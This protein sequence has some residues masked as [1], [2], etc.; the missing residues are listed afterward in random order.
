ML[1]CMEI[2]NRLEVAALWQ[3]SSASFP[4]GGAGGSGMK[5]Q[6]DAT[7][8]I[9]GLL[10]S[11]RQSF[12]PATVKSNVCLN[13]TAGKHHIQLSCQSLLFPP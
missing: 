7:L 4:D 11:K 1:T 12:L 9:T 8:R 2:G 5:W 13:G 10:R 3:C 6:E